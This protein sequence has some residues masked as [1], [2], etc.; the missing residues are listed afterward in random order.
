MTS[1][2]NPDPSAV[3]PREMR[4]ALESARRRL[5]EDRLDESE[6]R[7]AAELR[8]ALRDALTPADPIA[9]REPD[10]PGAPH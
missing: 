5:V 4:E 10:L 3:A 1:R 9:P 7:T 6:P 8:A 2:H